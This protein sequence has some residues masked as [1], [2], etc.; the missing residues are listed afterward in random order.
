M[1][2]ATAKHSTQC[3][4]AST[5]ATSLPAQ[6]EPARDRTEANLDG[7]QKPVFG[8]KPAL[9]QAGERSTARTQGWMSA[10]SAVSTTPRAS[11]GH[12]RSLPAVRTPYRRPY[13]SPAPKARSRLAESAPE[14]SWHTSPNC[15]PASDKRGAGNGIREVGVPGVASPGATPSRSGFRPTVE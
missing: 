3:L 11:S 5:H 10:G 12:F 4:L 13:R 7:K 8:K 15:R 1:L 6:T 9:P 14:A 2:R